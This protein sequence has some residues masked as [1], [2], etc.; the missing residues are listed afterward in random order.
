[1][2]G[3]PEILEQVKLPAK[4]STIDELPAFTS[5]A[6]ASIKQSTSPCSY[7]DVLPCWT[8]LTLLTLGKLIAG[9]ERTSAEARREKPADFVKVTVPRLKTMLEKRPSLPGLFFSLY[10]S[11]SKFE[12]NLLSRLSGR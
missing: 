1:M 3:P 5:Y 7:I 9:R 2:I 12:M 11:F 10:A 8:D 4:Y 6:A